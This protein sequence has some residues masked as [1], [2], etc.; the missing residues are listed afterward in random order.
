MISLPLATRD[1]NILALSRQHRESRTGSTSATWQLSSRPLFDPTDLESAPVLIWK[2]G[3]L[4]QPVVDY[5][6]AGDIVTFVVA[7]IAGDRVTAYFYFVAQ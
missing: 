1:P 6:I 4:L 5:T 2:N 3:A 7:P